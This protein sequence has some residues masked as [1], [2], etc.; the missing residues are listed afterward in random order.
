MNLSMR[1]SSA[2][3]KRRY[4]GAARREAAERKRAQVL[5]AA[6]QLFEG[7]GYAATTV[8]QVASE[9]GVSVETIYKKFGGKAGLVRALFYR[10]L[11]GAGPTPAEVRSDAMSS[12]ELS[13]RDVLRG[14]ADLVAEV[15]PRGSPIVLL[16]HAA[17]TTDPEAQ[18]LVEEMNAQRLARM[19]HNAKR[20]RGKPG[21]RRGL[22]IAEIRDVLFT[23]SASE[24]YDIL[25][26]HRGWSLRRFSDFVFAGMC[27][28]L[29]DHP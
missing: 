21:L 9:A 13:A 12:A 3:V 2:G 8:Q 14:W 10:G 16:I 27:A 26:L 5:D 24:L 19:T 6:M 15:S 17:A 1:P 23:Y 11:A 22:R 28:H 20:L 29:L 7:H 25:V 4:D 18:S